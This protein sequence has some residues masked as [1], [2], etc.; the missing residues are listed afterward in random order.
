ME[1]TRH[2]YVAPVLRL[3]D[4][5]RQYYLPVPDEIADVLLT[6]GRRI[7]CL[8]NGHEVKRAI[9]RKQDGERYLVLSRPLLRDASAVPGDMVEVL[10]WSDPAPDD[11]DIAEEF[12]VALEQDEEA[13][14]RFYAMTPG[15]QRSIAH[16]VN[17]GK[18]VETRIKRALELAHK[19]RTYTLSGD[20]SRDA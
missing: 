18:R 9:H 16:Y 6:S 2:G 7:I 4:G 8:M 10:I 5:I 11:I 3:G 19:L 15:K 12:V 1:T 17:S 13:A 14:L 20:L